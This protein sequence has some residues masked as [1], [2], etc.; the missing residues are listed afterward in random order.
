VCHADNTPDHSIANGTGRI[1]HLFADQS[2]RFHLNMLKET[3]LPVAK[4]VS[5]N[6]AF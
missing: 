1:A 6:P 4:N 5:G 2:D 3:L